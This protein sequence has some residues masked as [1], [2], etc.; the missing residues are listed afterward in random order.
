MTEAEWLACADPQEMLGFL[1]ARGNVGVRKLRLVVCACCRRAWPS[2]KNPDSR[3]AVELAER[4]ADGLAT[5]QELGEAGRK[6]H[7][8]AG[9]IGSAYFQLSQEQYLGSD[10]AAEEGGGEEVRPDRP[11]VEWR[12]GAAVQA[13]SWAAW[14]KL[15]EAQ[16]EHGLGAAR[17]AATEPVSERTQQAGV[18]QDVFGNPFR[19]VA[20]DVGWQTPTIIALAQAAYDDRTL[21]AGTLDNARL[22]LLA[23]ALEEAG[24]DNADIL[25]HLRSPGPHV[26]GCWVLDLLLGKE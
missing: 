3:R 12:E 2:L 6:A 8:L 24:C 17:R 14:S 18:I 9:L 1:K 4:F 7:E 22:S 21:P 25:S 11:R 26:R 13:A 23:D 5:P 20:V 19:P 10:E 15:T 16:A